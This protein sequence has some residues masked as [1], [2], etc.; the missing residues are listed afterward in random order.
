MFPWES[1]DTGE[2][3][4][5]DWARGLDGSII[6]ITTSTEYHITAD[7]AYAV[8][9]YYTATGNDEFMLRYG[10]E[11]LFETARFWASC[12][13]YDKEKRHYEIRGVIGPDEFHEN[14]NNNAYTNVMVK[15]NLLRAIELYSL[16][17]KKHDRRRRLA[18]LAKRIRLDKKELKSWG[19][20]AAR[21]I[22]Q[23]YR[24]A[25][26]IEEFDGYFGLKDV[27]ITKLDHNFMPL[28]PRGITQ[29]NVAKTQ[30]VKQAD[31]VMLLYLSVIFSARRR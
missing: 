16:F 24:K 2:D 27:A 9:H 31:V 12:A 7:I 5:P 1:A 14:I 10:L 26:A 23:I 19:N 15:W 22:T 8:S 29:R 6:E 3:T 25:G 21:L 17:S 18:K 13:A 11:I 30:L 20:I 4:T 28:F